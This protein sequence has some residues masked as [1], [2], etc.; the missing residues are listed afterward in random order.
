MHSMH[1]RPFPKH[2][3]YFQMG[4]K[5]G[6]LHEYAD[7]VN[8]HFYRRFEEINNEEARIERER[9]R[10][11]PVDL[12][13]HRQAVANLGQA[14]THALTYAPTPPI[15]T[16]DLSDTEYYTSE[17]DFSSDEKSCPMEPHMTQQ[18]IDELLREAAPVRPVVDFHNEVKE[19]SKYDDEDDTPPVLLD[20]HMEEEK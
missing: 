15:V 19:E 8:D 18:E 11:L 13:R 2:A 9:Q 1:L 6:P 12:Q 20:S 16:D 10:Q 3:Q 4:K 7:D 17:D 14:R 5:V